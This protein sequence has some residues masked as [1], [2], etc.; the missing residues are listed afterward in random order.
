[1]SH[2]KTVTTTYQDKAVLEEAFR[3]ACAELGFTAQVGKLT[4][5]M[6]NGETLPVS[7]C[8][9]RNRQFDSFYYGDFGL[10]AQSDGTFRIIIDDHDEKREKVQ[11]FL[12]K[13][14]QYYGWRKTV[15]DFEAQGFVVSQE[16][17]TTVAG[18]IRFKMRLTRRVL[19]VQT[20]NTEKQPAQVAVWR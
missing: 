15:K 11:T 17:E 10:T 1:M 16:A 19:D 9:R 13:M 6:Y 5:Q 4:A 3:D 14:A 12:N 18:D 2:K 8:I 20:T 7:M